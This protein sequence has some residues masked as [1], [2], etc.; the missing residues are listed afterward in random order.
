MHYQQEDRNSCVDFI[1]FNWFSTPS[2]V[3][4]LYG[5][6]IPIRYIY[7][8]VKLVDTIDPNELGTN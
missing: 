6:Y 1:S 2:N 3:G 8:L 7:L 4:K 5:I